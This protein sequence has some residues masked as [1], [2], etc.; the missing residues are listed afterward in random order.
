[1]RS[2]NLQEKSTRIIFTI[3]YHAKF[4]EIVKAISL[5]IAIVF[6]MFLTIFTITTTSIYSTRTLYSS[7]NSFPL[8]RVNQSIYS[9]SPLMLYFTWTTY[10][11]SVNQST[12]YWINADF[13]TRSI[14][15]VIMTPFE[16]WS[17]RNR[18]R[19]LQRIRK[20]YKDFL[21]SCRF[22]M[23]SWSISMLRCLRQII[24]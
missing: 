14:L 7:W 13:K 4:M 2:R 12:N 5:I 1:M 11:W 6:V 20:D 19:L 3:V 9:S 22:K 8:R 21:L 10:F 24:F 23:I 17:L 16:H 15:I 18:T